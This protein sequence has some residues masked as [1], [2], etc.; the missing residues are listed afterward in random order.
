MKSLGK[1]KHFLSFLAEIHNS[2]KVHARDFH[3]NGVDDDVEVKL[4]HSSNDRLSRLVIGRN[5]E[6]RVFLS[7]TPKGDT[8]LVLIRT[9]LRLDCDL[10]N[11]IRK[12]IGLCRFL[13]LERKNGMSISNGRAP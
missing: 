8:H 5:L 9:R 10:N 2:I 3:S 7:K 6:T 4:A 1:K 11:R 13:I 12:Q